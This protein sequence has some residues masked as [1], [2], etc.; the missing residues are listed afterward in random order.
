MA[1]FFTAFDHR[2]FV[3]VSKHLPLLAFSSC[4]WPRMFA[5]RLLCMYPGI[6]HELLVLK[7]NGYID[8]IQEK[9]FGEIKV[10]LEHKMAAPLLDSDEE[11]EDNGE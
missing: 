8:T 9:P 7:T 3:H 10:R 5:D 2:C 11:G 1:S 4:F 6:F